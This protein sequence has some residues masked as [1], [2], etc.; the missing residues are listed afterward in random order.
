MILDS[1]PLKITTIAYK[2]HLDYNMHSNHIEPIR[3]N[4]W[5]DKKRTILHIVLLSKERIH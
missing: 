2:L 3:F 5:I 1:N 4:G